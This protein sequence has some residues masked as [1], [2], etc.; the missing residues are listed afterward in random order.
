MS[1]SK[2]TRRNRGIAHEK[3]EGLPGAN[4]GHEFAF[5]GA[6]GDYE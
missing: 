5:G 3:K 4:H 2:G 1:S 6:S